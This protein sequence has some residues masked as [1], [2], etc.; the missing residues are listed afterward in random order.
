MAWWN[1]L[2]DMTQYAGFTRYLGDDRDAIKMVNFAGCTLTAMGQDFKGKAPLQTKDKESRV[3]EICIQFCDAKWFEQN[4]PDCK[5]MVDDIGKTAGRDAKQFT[6]K[7]DAALMKG[8]DLD[9]LLRTELAPTVVKI[10]KL[11]E[12]FW[13]GYLEETGGSKEGAKEFEKEQFEKKRLAAEALRAMRKHQKTKVEKHDYGNFILYTNMSDDEPLILVSSDFKVAIDEEYLLAARKLSTSSTKMI[14]GLYR[15]ADG[16]LTEFEIRKGAA[17]VNDFRDALKALRSARTAVLVDK[18]TIDKKKVAKTGHTDQTERD[19][20]SQLGELRKEAKELLKKADEGQFWVCA[21]AADGDPFIA[22]TKDWKKAVPKQD[23][24]AKIK[25]ASTTAEAVGKWF[26]DPKNGRSFTYE[27]TTGKLT[28]NNM[29]DAIKAARV[30]V[31]A[32]PSPKAI[33]AYK[34]ERFL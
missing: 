5:A 30:T 28:A 32:T 18:D 13:K 3:V 29:S 4:A 21:E 7:K 2:T 6:E 27:F 20:L 16:N 1:D 14:E 25:K 34:K 24:L 11:I 22:V 31:T 9:K 8:Y 33:D 15:R 10:N 17:T 23:E 19:Q 12:R 26:A